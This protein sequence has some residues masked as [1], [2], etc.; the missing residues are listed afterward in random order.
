MKKHEVLQGGIFSIERGLTAMDN[1]L[2]SYIVIECPLRS[3]PSNSVMIVMYLL[4]VK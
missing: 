3:G 2:Y 1:P 4:L